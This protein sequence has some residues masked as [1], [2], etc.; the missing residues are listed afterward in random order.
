MKIILNVDAITHPLTGIGN[1]ATQLAQRLP[2]HSDIEDVRLFSSHKWVSSTENIADSNRNLAMLRKNLPLKSSALKIYNMQKNFWFQHKSRKFASDYIFHSPNFLLMPY[3]GKSVVTIHDLSYLRFPETHPKER[4]KLLNKELP[5]SL[6][7]AQAIITISEYVKLEILKNFSI[8]EEKIHVVTLGVSNRFRPKTREE[9]MPVLKKYK[10]QDTQY[11]LSVATLEPRK[12]LNGLLDAYSILPSAIRQKYKLVIIGA[13]GWLNK[14]LLRRIEVLQRRGEIIA[15]G[16]VEEKD[17][18]DL[19]AG[20]H[21]FALPS[22]YEGFGLPVLEAMASGIPVLT[23]DSSSMPEV[24]G[25]C[26]ILT[27][28]NDISNISSGLEKL[29][30]DNHWQK[31][32]ISLGLQRA[33]TFSWDNCVDRTVQVYKVL[34]GNY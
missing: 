28:A 8:N 5:K 11:L 31:S 2:H 21:A 18:P 12:N 3:A 14:N 9:L 4:I 24:A 6:T 1:Y 33:K 13:A 20:A 10:L 26:A 23:S 16:Y 29:L 34:A 25:N 17:L 7:R 30:T 32:A 27:D 22:L 19:Y 15:T